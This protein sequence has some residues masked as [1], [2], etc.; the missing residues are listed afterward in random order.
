MVNPKLQLETADVEK[1]CSREKIQFNPHT[2]EVECS[3]EQLKSLNQSL[4][5]KCKSSKRD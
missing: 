3:V 4:I 2:M 1:V 5:D